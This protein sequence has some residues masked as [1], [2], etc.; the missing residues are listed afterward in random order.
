MKLPSV[1]SSLESLRP[2][3]EQGGLI[4]F[5]LA[6]QCGW[7]LEHPNGLLV[8]LAVD[9][10]SDD[11]TWLRQATLWLASTAAGLDDSLQLDEKA[12]WLVRRHAATIE[13]AELEA[14]L[15]QMLSIARW[16][17]VLGE[18]S[19]DARCTSVTENLA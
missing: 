16:F 19:S 13:P 3:G 1:F 4:H 10:D 9:R 14:S 15:S 18:A 7:T 12:I 2:V 17:A 5:K 6:D 8:A 11:D